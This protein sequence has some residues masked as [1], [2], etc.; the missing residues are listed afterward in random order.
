MKTILAL[1]VS[2]HFV[3]AQAETILGE[4]PAPKP[5]EGVRIENVGGKLRVVSYKLSEVG[6]PAAAKVPATAGK[7][8][9]KATAGELVW[10]AYN[11]DRPI[12]AAPAFTA[13]DLS[14][15]TI[16]TPDSVRDFAAG[17][18]SGVDRDGNLQNGYAVQIAPFRLL[19]VNPDLIDYRQKTFG[20]WATRVLYNTG[21]S[22]ATTNA[23]DD[24]D[25]IRLALGLEAT[26]IDTQEEKI[27]NAL[28]V[29]QD[30][31]LSDRPRRRA[32]ESIEAFEARLNEWAAQ[33]N[34]NYHE[35]RNRVLNTHY[36]GF[37]LSAAYAPTWL[38]ETGKFGDLT[39]DGSST[40]VTT[41]WQWYVNGSDA[42]DG[43]IG[44]ERS[45][46]PLISEFELLGHLRYQQGKQVVDPSDQL[47]T[48][49]QD[50]LI[51]AVGLRFGNSDWHAMVEASY[52]RFF[53]GLEGEGDGFRIGGGFERRLA[54]NL[55]FAMQA[56]H[57][58]GSGGSDEDFF[59]IGTFRF[60]T[61][62]S[63]IYTRKSLNLDRNASTGN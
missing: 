13:L 57:D 29:A 4:V 53:D 36:N 8:S 44:R 60:G 58:F 11:L 25:E 40:W 23:A 43:K 26:L 31:A 55:W 3:T 32:K 41:S 27:L 16:S 54:E 63:P 10:P 46:Q 18:L 24:D 59:A 20:G 33:V 28:A 42:D 17:V 49:E 2:F 45:T 12:A 22:I 47:R 39:W 52:L 62:D 15:E 5:G 7:P 48:A 61:S 6:A 19:G 35:A 51:A 30:Q 21:L 56:G 9:A 14:P 34:T 37:K 38:S 50:M 1:A